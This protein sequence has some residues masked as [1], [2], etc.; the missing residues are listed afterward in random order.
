MDTFALSKLAEEAR[1]TQLGAWTSCPLQTIPKNLMLRICFHLNID[2]MR[3][4]KQTCRLFYGTL[5]ADAIRRS[6]GR[7]YRGRL[8][9]GDDEGENGRGDCPS[10]RCRMCL[11]LFLAPDGL[12]WTAA[13]DFQK[14]LR[15]LCWGC[16]NA[17]GM[18]GDY[19]QHLYFRGMLPP[20]CGYCHIPLT[21]AVKLAD[22][23]TVCARQRRLEQVLLYL[24]IVRTLPLTVATLMSISDDGLPDFVRAPL[25]GAMCMSKGVDKRT[26][27]RNSLLAVGVWNRS[28]GS[29]LLVV[30]GY[31][32]AAYT[33]SDYRHVGSKPW[34]KKAKERGQFLETIPPTP[35]DTD[36]GG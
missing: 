2:S 29:L 5:D 22:H 34:L 24:Q 32:D 17:H 31:A 6:H 28:K 12:V 3:A 16:A 4:L 30:A 7:V 10:K 27:A 26:A 35:P 19:L 15:A 9:Y 18:T 1:V 36:Y 33:M 11:Q 21:M 25:W 14:P 13:D 23:S 20:L 8:Y